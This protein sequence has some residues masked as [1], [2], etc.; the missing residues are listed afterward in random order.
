MY[1]ETDTGIATR[2]SSVAVIALVVLATVATAALGG[3]ASADAA[4]FYGALAKPVWA[5]SAGLFG[6]VWTA[7]YTMMAVAAILLIRRAGPD[8]ARRGLRLYYG[9][10]ALNALWSW[11]FFR[12]RLGGAAFLDVVLLVALVTA[13]MIRFHEESAGAALLLLPYLAWITFAAGLTFA[14]WRMNPA[15]L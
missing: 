4:A 7:L 3:L 5:P 1:P 6:P 13:M 14:V 8:G 12:W 2:P 11:L 15:L 9:Q 10:L